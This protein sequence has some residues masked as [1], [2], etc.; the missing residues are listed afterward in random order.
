M[1]EATFWAKV[2][3]AFNNRPHA[4]ARKLHAGMFDEGLPDAIYVVDGVQGL[5][6]LKYVPAW[7]AR[8][9]T[10]VPC[11]LTVN[12]REWMADWVAHAGR[13]HLLLGVA[14]EWFLFDV[15]TS[16]DVRYDRLAFQ[17]QRAE[18]RAGTL[19]GLKAL[20]ELMARLPGPALD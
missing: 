3:K 13:A 17:G 8:E 19:K 7:P 15:P 1:N 20:P 9:A 4:R 14:Q 18:R 2:R 5:L 12:Q 11:G 10:T 16:A 6:E